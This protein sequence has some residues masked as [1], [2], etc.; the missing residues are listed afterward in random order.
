MLSL[1]IT[2][3][4]KRVVFSQQ[5]HVK[6]GED[7]SLVIQDGEAT[8]SIKFIQKIDAPEP[9]LVPFFSPK[10]PSAY[11]KQDGE[12]NE[13]G[14]RYILGNFNQTKITTNPI[15]F[16]KKPE[17]GRY[18]FQISAM[19]ISSNVDDPSTIWLYTVTVYEKDAD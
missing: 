8:A 13:D 16:Y 5:F 6:F 7:F 3:G 14:V 4:S 17:G 10:R 2:A 15:P 9:A 1:S 19:S 12:K 11:L 18:Y